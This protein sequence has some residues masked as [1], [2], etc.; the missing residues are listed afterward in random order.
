[1]AIEF[2]FTAFG[3]VFSLITA[4]IFIYLYIRYIIIK[5]QTLIEVQ[6]V[7]KF[8]ILMEILN[9]L[10]VGIHF[11]HSCLIYSID[12]GEIYVTPL[13]FW[14]SA[15]LNI[16]SILRPIAIL[17]LGLD[18]ILIILFP[19]TVDSKR[20]MFSFFIGISFM[21]AST[22][23][24]LMTRILPNIPTKGFIASCITFY[25]LAKVGSSSIFTALRMISGSSN[26]VVGALLLIMLKHRFKVMQFVTIK[27]K[28]MMLVILTLLSTIIWNFLPNLIGFIV[29]LVS[30]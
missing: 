3:A 13:L 30:L 21:T 14:N 9:G 7:L 25:C 26:F 19:T 2:S 23:L 6:D 29:Y 11:T 10:V 27:N 8:Y 22:V 1:M 16:T 18:R 17:T 4:V 15:L 24:L 20:K 12:D 28:N 5:T